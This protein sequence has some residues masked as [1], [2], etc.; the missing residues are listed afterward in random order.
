MSLF[1]RNKATDSILVKLETSCTAIP[2]AWPDL[3]KFCH[4]CK[5][6]QVSG[7]YLTVYFLFGKMFSLLWQIWYIIGLIFIVANGQIM[8]NNLT[9]WSQWAHMTLNLI[10]SSEP[11]INWIDCFFFQSRYTLVI[12]FVVMEA[13][14]HLRHYH[15][16]H[17]LL[18]RQMQITLILVLADLVRVLGLIL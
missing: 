10:F 2:S 6:F 9:I 3:T 12:F 11:R 15:H 13:F 5:D 17:P 18:C 16:H 7:K 8:I 14:N 4:F 1:V